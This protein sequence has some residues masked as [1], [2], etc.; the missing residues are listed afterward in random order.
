MTMP[1]TSFKQVDVFTHQPFCG[2]PV[3]V[4]MDAQ[5]L[6]SAQMQR[7]AHWTNLSET[8][9]VLPATSPEADYRVRIFTPQRELPFAGHPTI[10][11]AHALMEAGR[12]TP[13]QQQLVQ[14]C[15][16]GLISLAVTQPE[17][18]PAFIAFSLPEP[19]ITPLSAAQ[20]Q[21]LSTLLNCKLSAASPPV[22]VDVG[23]RWIVAQGHNARRVAQARP[24]FAGLATLDRELEATGS[25]L[26]GYQDGVLPCAIE[27][28]SFAPAC[29]IPEDPVC[30]SGNGAVAAFIREYSLPV[31][32][33][34]E[35]RS[36][37]GSNVG[38]NGKITLTIKPDGISVA[39]QA[40]TCIEGELTLPDR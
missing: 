1:T 11:T 15:E 35:L 32:E 37:Q 36:Y 3:A 30:G 18:G 29:G 21:R 7:I 12:I 2:N 31:P 8:T 25:C 6:S 17:Q 13:Q 38:R 26:F 27:V 34:R 40:V 4:V 19:T 24:D 9:F 33:S 23:P 10:G 22:L 16:A 39:G 14:E 28:R 20:A 5:G